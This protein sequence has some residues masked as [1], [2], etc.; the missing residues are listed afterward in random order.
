MKKKR[1]VKMMNYNELYKMCDEIYDALEEL[2]SKITE[3]DYVRGE[4]GRLM[5][6][7]EDV[8]G[9]L[10]DDEHDDTDA[11]LRDVGQWLGAQQRVS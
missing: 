9:Y 5:S 1:K 11:T 10:E 3:N 7:I 4:V 8:K 6:E 2:H